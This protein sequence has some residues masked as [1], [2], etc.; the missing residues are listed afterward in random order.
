MEKVSVSITSEHL[1]R[2]ESRADEDGTGRS[3]ALRAILDGEVRA[4]YKS[5]REE[6]EAEIT[7]LEAELEDVRAERDDL[8][9]LRARR[10]SAGG[11]AAHT[12]RACMTE[13]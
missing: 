8:R 4:E 5:V 9:R 12:R 13:R 1:E 6:C 2:I 7:D 10:R 11:V 3:A